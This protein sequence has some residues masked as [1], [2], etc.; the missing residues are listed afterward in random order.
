MDLLTDR[1]NIERR[2]DQINARLAELAVLA[3]VQP[4]TTEHDALMHELEQSLSALTL[5]QRL[6]K[7]R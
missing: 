7:E 6:P 2:V 4:H 1:A 3:A 5:L